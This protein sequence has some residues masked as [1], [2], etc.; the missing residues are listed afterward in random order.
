MPVMTDSLSA[1]GRLH[2][3]GTARHLVYVYDA[4]GWAL[5]NIGELLAPHF[6]AAGISCSLRTA[7][8]YYREP[9]PADVLYLAYSGLWD[10]RFDY[11][12]HA[13]EVICTFHDPLEVTY[14]TNRRDWPSR[15]L[16]A[17]RPERFDRISVISAEMEELFRERYGLHDVRRT[18]T[19]PHDADAIR[20]A[21]AA[22]PSHDGVTFCSATNASA[23]HPARRIYERIRNWPEHARDHQ[24]RLS[25][26]QLGSIFVRLNRKNIPLLGRVERAVSGLPAARTRFLH[27]RSAMLSRADY[28]AA[29]AESDVYVCT[30]NMEGGPLPVMEAVLAGLAVVSTPVGQVASWVTH[31]DNGFICRTEREFI[32]AARAYARNPD[33]LR[34]HRAS[35][36]RRATTMRFDPGPWIAFARGTA[37]SPRDAGLIAV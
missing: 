8:E 19:Y 5:H 9:E 31:G 32:E 4:R 18:P 11:R 6:R 10:P 13:R 30:S 1:A 3:P 15:P 37:Y 7:E 20:A 26:Q 34:R 28:L 2:E 23:Y 22:V 35:S 36:A 14:F 33:L 27:S 29:L 12:R 21:A 16:R 25:L 24:G 17:I